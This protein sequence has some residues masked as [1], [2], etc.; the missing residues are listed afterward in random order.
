MPKLTNRTWLE[1][2][3]NIFCNFQSLSM[4]NFNPKVA[5]TL[6]TMSRKIIAEI[7]RFSRETALPQADQ[8]QCSHL[9]YNVHAF[10][11]WRLFADAADCARH[12]HARTTQQQVYY[13]LLQKS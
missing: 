13:K 3:T 6:N 5:D 9:L 12:T 4:L 2:V 1:S 7:F 11:F 10:K 8:T